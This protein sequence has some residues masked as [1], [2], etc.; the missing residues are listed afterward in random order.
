M[1]ELLYKILTILNGCS[2][3]SKSALTAKISSNYKAA[4]KNATLFHGVENGLI[5]E[6]KIPSEKN[7]TKA[8]ALKVYY[9]TEKGKEALRIQDEF[10]EKLL[11]NPLLDQKLGENL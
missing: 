4:Q 9:I 7:N 1:D 6:L 2:S 5:G 10:L 8:T 11:Q 3:A